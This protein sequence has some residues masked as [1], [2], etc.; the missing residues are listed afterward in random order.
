[1]EVF[2]KGKRI[3]LSPK[4]LLGEGGEAKVYLY[5]NYA[6]KIYHQD[7]I[8]PK[9]ARK[10]KSFPKNLPTKLI[11][12]VDLLEDRKGD[13]IGFSMEVVSGA[14]PFIML[15]NK[16]F[17]GNFAVDAVVK[18]HL[19]TLATIRQIHSAGMIIGDLNDLNLLFRDKE[20]FFIDADSMQFG[21]FPCEVATEKFLD[22]RLYGIDFSARP[23][24]SRESDYYSYCVLLFEDLLLVNPFG[25]VHKD[26]PTLLKR[27]QKRVSVFNPKVMYPKA[28]I[29]YKVL[30]DDLLDY[31][32]KVFEKDLR[33]EFPEKL[34]GNLR[35]TKC[36]VCGNEHT[37]AVCP[38]CFQKAAAAVKEVELVNKKCI[39]AVIFKTKGSILAAKEEEGKIKWLY[40]ENGIVKREDG[41]KVMLQ[42]PDIFT[43]FAIMGD[44]TLV[45]RE[46]KIIIVENEKV[47]DET[48]TNKLG[49]FP[50]FEC[51][52]TDYFRLQGDL[53]LKDENKIIG[54][55]LENQTWIRVGKNF[56]FGFYRVGGKSVY[57]IFSLEK[58][59]INDSIQLPKI[60][61]HLIDAEAVF[62][63]THVMFLTSTMEAGKMFNSMYLIDAK[64]N[65]L[66]SAKEE[67]GNSRILSSI[68]NKVLGGGKIITASDEGLILLEP[69]SGQIK[70]VKIFTDTE[71][72]VDEKVQL[73]TGGGGLYVVSGQGINLL[74]LA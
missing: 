1:M 41:K 48:M 55:I 35:W 9:R 29:P 53:L 26:Y 67:A 65:L 62:S 50:V 60:S 66:A 37:R 28:A 38:F 24:F 49:N 70:E 20:A 68:H 25:G 44:K 19:D 58:A 31:F 73:F 74:K 14:E 27:A 17:R 12:P 61:G 3:I 22:P 51:S 8:T 43:R 2:L 63:D 6:I 18:I 64:G 42:K 4:D 10:L 30:S 21:N 32:L 40:E 7:F 36:T 56:G 39:A 52:G 46:K 47:V 5:G 34:I 16:R 71:P 69:D 72:F 13:I 59:D 23:S 45:G 57:F 11:A 33:G 54:Q 15:S